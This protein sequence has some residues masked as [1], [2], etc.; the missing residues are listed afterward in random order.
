MVAI[1]RGTPVIVPT[2]IDKAFKLQPQD[3]RSARCAAHQVGRAQLALEPVGRGLHARRAQGPDGR[4][5]APSAG[6]GA[7]RRHIRASGL[8]RLR[9][10]D[11]RANRAGLEGADAD[12][13]R[14]LQILRHDRLAHRLRGRAPELIKAMDLVQGQ[15][16][17]RGLHDRAMG[18]GRGAG[19][20]PQDHIPARRKAFEERRDLVVSMLG[21]AKRLEVSDAGGARSMSS[22]PARARSAGRRARAEMIGTDEDFVTELLEEEGVAAD[23]GQ[24]F[25]PRP[26]T[27]RVSYATSLEALE[28]ACKKIQ[29]FTAELR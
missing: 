23:A 28:N 11:A 18:V 6:M 21:Q 27:S 12:H 20:G 7:D 22:R 16:T 15:Q 13:E 4:L 19:T 24:R 1:N 9:L 8:R 2:T 14:R 29:K 5:D 25:R 3:L 17:S 10:R 26:P